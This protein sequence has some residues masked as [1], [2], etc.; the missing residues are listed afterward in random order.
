MCVLKHM[1]RIVG[2]SWPL[3]QHIQS[4]SPL[5]LGWIIGTV[6]FIST[7]VKMYLP[8]VAKCKIPFS[9]T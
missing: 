4:S 6:E 3:T 5:E 8:Q 7:I 1:S 2:L 9:T